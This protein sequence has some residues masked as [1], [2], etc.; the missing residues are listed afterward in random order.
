MGDGAEGYNN[1]IGAYENNV[2]ASYCRIITIN[3]LHEKVPCV[4][5]MLQAT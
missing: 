5:A 2:R 4:I 3:P 1:M